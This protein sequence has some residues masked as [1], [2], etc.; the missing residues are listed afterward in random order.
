MD[1]PILFEIHRWYHA[2]DGRRNFK[3]DRCGFSLSP[4]D[5]R[6]RH[7]PV[8]SVILNFGIK[9]DPH[10]YNWKQPELS[11]SLCEDCAQAFSEY[12]RLGI[13]AAAYRRLHE[14]LIEASTNQTD[15]E[16]CETIVAL[17][18]GSLGRKAGEYDRL[19]NVGINEWW[20]SLSG[21]IIA[22]EE[23]QE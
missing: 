18:S 9:N 13:I 2:P 15:R 14:V 10:H 5:L 3:C 12:H 16:E 4:K 6:N 20:P 7:L 1:G 17:L 21:M 23:G 19:S 8:H 22:H 11:V